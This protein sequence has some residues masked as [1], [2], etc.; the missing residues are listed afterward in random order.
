MFGYK[1]TDVS[2]E[3]CASIIKV[4]DCSSTLKTA[5]IYSSDTPLNFNHMNGVP[6]QM[7]AILVLIVTSCYAGTDVSK[8]SE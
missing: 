7:T 5:A 3:I 1:L 8:V 6:F 2:K 4:E